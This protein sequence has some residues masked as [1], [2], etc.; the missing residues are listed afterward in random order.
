MPLDIFLGVDLLRFKMSPKLMLDISKLSIQ[1]NSYN[2]AE[3]L[4]ND[5]LNLKISDDTIRDVTNFIGQ[6]V[7]K[8]DCRFANRLQEVSKN[9]F[10][11]AEKSAY[12][13]IEVDGSFIHVRS[14]DGKSARWC[15]VK[16]GLV[17][18]SKNFK[19]VLNKDGEYEIRLGKREYTCYL[20]S[21][22]QFKKFLLSMCTRNN[23]DLYD[24]I[25]M[26]TDGA[27]WIKS[28]KKEYFPKA[29]QI[30][31]FFHLS[32]NTYNFLKYIYKDNLNLAE[33]LWKEWCIY[34]KEGQYKKVLDLTKKYKDQK[35]GVG[36]TNIYNYIIKNEE[37]INYPRYMAKDVF[38]GSGAI[39]SANKRVVQGRLKNPGMIWNGIN[40]QYILSLVAK[41]YSDLWDLVE[42]IVLDYFV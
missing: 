28:I 24:D 39:E 12:L 33:N 16:T 19:K 11:L 18:S 25:V 23:Y 27:E 42:K 3:K 41:Y 22:D 5:N 1:L 36:I 37:N 31:D 32:E 17:A 29:L 34:Y 13:L 35:L 38:I 8:Y 20:G 21:V 15:E 30:L 7:Y 2:Q 6:L 4:L 9:E 40:A 26:L 10:D 14:S